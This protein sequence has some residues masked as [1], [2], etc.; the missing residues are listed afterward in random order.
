M[1]NVENSRKSTQD[2][3]KGRIKTKTKIIVYT[4]HIIIL[5]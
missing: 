1:E 5:I 2:A 4:K 3:I